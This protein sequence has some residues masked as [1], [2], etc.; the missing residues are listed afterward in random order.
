MNLKKIYIICRGRSGGT[1][2]S[3][4]FQSLYTNFVPISFESLNKKN[5]SIENFLIEN[6]KIFINSNQMNLYKKLLNKKSLK[7]ENILV[8]IDIFS[9]LSSS[10]GYKY[11]LFKITP[12]KSNLINNKSLQEIAYDKD[13][14]FFFF[15]RNIMDIYISALKAKKL[16]KW[17]VIDTTTM[18]LNID[19]ERFYKFYKTYVRWILGNLE[20]LKSTKRVNFFSYEDIF[21]DEKKIITKFS[22]SFNYLIDAY[23][24]GNDYNN[25]VNLLDNFTKQ[26]KSLNWRNKINNCDEIDEFIISKKI[27][28]NPR[29]IISSSDVTN[30][31]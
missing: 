15:F 10:V 16:K 2:L 25:T 31:F 14:E 28:L 5:M 7:T 24:H 21:N 26:D 27:E 9:K 22:E 19:K 18:T 1:I 17:S 29:K 6:K 8:Y 12:H 3:H 30:S 13:S 23:D 20:I 4:L 11:A